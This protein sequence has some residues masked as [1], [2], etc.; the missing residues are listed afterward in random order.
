MPKMM[1]SLGVPEHRKVFGAISSITTSRRSVIASGLLALEIA[2]VVIV[3]NASK[4]QASMAIGARYPLEFGSRNKGPDF[5][6]ET[7][8]NTASPRDDH[9]LSSR[10]F[11]N[12]K[13]HEQNEEAKQSVFPPTSWCEL[14]SVGSQGKGIGGGR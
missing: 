12:I 2:L 10:F 6:S 1:Q 9:R 13:E 14:V 8:N 3:D 7:P 5:R 11:R 4:R